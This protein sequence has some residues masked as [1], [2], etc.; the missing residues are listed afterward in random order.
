MCL[1][2]GGAAYDV[3]NPRVTSP[4]FT[5][6][7]DRAEIDEQLRARGIEMRL[8]S[9]VDN[10]TIRRI[11]T[12]LRDMMA[13]EGFTDADVSHEVTAVAGGPKLVNVTFTNIKLIT[14]HIDDFLAA[15]QLALRRHQLRP[16]LA[17]FGHLCCIRL[18]RGRAHRDA[19]VCHREELVDDC[20][21]AVNLISGELEGL[22]H[23]FVAHG[24]VLTRVVT[25]QSGTRSGCQ[26]RQVPACGALPRSFVSPWDRGRHSLSVW[27]EKHRGVPAFGTPVWVDVTAGHFALL[28]CFRRDHH[29]VP[30][31]SPIIQPVR[32]EVALSPGTRLGPYEITAQIGVGGMG[33]VYSAI[34]TK[35]NRQVALRILSRSLQPAPLSHRRK[36]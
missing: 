9:F 26:K 4:R 15:V 16:P 21:E 29:T 19:R 1:F 22:E 20:G 17:Q 27:S 11:E 2:R 18:S 36:S 7:I 6:Q 23:Q 8:D 14:F 28:L 35:L 12:V 32:I 30:P 24:R 3:G 25:P 5:T 13:N 31:V 10:G 33:E 34:D